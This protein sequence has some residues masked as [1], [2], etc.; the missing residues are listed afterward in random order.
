[1]LKI[2]KVELSDE[3]DDSVGEEEDYSDAAEEAFMRKQR[4]CHKLNSGL[5]SIN[6]INRINEYKEAQKSRTNSD[7]ASH[8]T[9]SIIELKAKGY[10]DLPPRKMENTRPNIYIDMA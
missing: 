10:F 3:D 5:K 8:K 7:S 9:R 6:T 4:I 1:M 2:H